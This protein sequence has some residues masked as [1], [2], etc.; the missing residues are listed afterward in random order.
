MQVAVR[1]GLDEVAA[2]AGH[3]AEAVGDGAGRLCWQGAAAVLGPGRRQVDQRPLARVALVPE[4]KDVGPAHH[5]PPAPGVKTL[6][7]L[8]LL[9][10]P[11]LPTLCFFLQ[12][13]EVALFG[14]ARGDA[15]FLD[16]RKKGGCG[17]GRGGRALR[18]AQQ[19]RQVLQ[20]QRLGAGGLGRLQSAHDKSQHS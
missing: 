1:G 20:Q 11:L 4:Y 3:H 5:H 2:L 8:L 13:V 17:G 12:D 10:L 16:L 9:Y 7:P 14:D 19:V 6:Q 18:P 15:D